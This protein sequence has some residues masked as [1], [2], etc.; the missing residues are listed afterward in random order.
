[1]TRGVLGLAGAVGLGGWAGAGEAPAGG[2]VRLYSAEK[3]AIAVLDKVLKPDKQWRRQLTPEQ[4]EVLRRK[5]TERAFTGAYW[6]HHEDGVYTCA[7]CG[8][9]LFRSAD[10]FESGTGWPSFS[11]PV[12][13]ENLRTEEDR[14]FFMVRTEVLCRRCDGH[15]GHVFPDGP[16]PGGLRYCIN[17]AALG[18]RP[19]ETR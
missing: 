7:A 15:L 3:G 5:G 17:S 1:M 6:D 2:P 16:K 8:T 11:A 10:K 4:Y 13:P 18:F 19:A 14:G 9:D 12:A